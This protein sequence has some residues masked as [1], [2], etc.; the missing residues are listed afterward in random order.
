VTALLALFVAIFAFGQEGGYF[1][2]VPVVPLVAM[3][4]AWR[5]GTDVNEYGLRV[6]RPFLRHRIIPWTEVS[7]LHPDAKGRAAVTLVNGRTVLLRAVKASDLPRVIA[8]SGKVP[9]DSADSPGG[10]GPDAPAAQ[11]QA[12]Q[13]A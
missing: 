10:V 11:E 7:T 9:A 3:I 1:W 4:W 6:R 5:A 12:G 8:A 13:R 2:L